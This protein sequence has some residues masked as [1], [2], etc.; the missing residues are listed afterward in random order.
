MEHHYRRGRDGRGGVAYA[1]RLYADVHFL[2]PSC[3]PGNGT[4]ADTVGVWRHA[5]AVADAGGGSARRSNK[6]RNPGNREAWFA[7]EKPIKAIKISEFEV[8]RGCV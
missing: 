3:F 2:R 6:E 8:R 7:S 4:A 5:S 1:R